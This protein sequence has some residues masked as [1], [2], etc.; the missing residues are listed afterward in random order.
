MRIKPKIVIFTGTSISHSEASN[1][2][3]ATYMPPIFRGNIKKVILEGYNIIGIIDGIFFNKAAV[4]H[5]EIIEAL[6]LGIVIVGGS[7]MGALRAAEMDIHGMIGVGKIY[8]WYKNGVLEDDDE[9]AVATNPDTFEQ[10]SD[11]MVNIRETL[12]AAMH[13]D[14]ID[15]NMLEELIKIAKKTPYTHRSYLGTINKA[16]KN[17]TLSTHEADNLL[18]YCRI[19][20]INTKKDDAKLVLK[21]I[22]TISDNFIY[23]N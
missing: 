12:N 18:N 10:L 14:I 16:L 4:A 23:S 6:K 1:I 17:N 22:K 7:S 5:K 3:Q 2:L 8:N 21:K 9:V 11:P 15:L 13:E 19:Q 20:E